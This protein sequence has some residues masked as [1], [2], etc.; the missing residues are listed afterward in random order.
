MVKLLIIL[1]FSCLLLPFTKSYAQENKI[2]EDKT[3]IRGT[4]THI[5]SEKPAYGGIKQQVKVRLDTKNK[6]QVTATYSYQSQDKSMQKLKIGESVVV[7]KTMI[8]NKTMYAVYDRFRLPTMLILVVVFFVVILVTTGR[9]GIG[10]IAGLLIS[11]AVILLFIVP[12]ILEGADP[13]FIS[14]IGCLFIMVTTIYLAHGFSQRTSIAIAGTFLSLI[15]TGILAV[16]FVQLLKLTGTGNEDAYMLQ[17]GQHAINLRGLLLGG[18]M[19]GTLGVLDDTTTTQA[20]TVYTLSETS[21]TLTVND[22]IRKGMLVGREHITSLV[23][24]LVLAYAGASLPIFIFFILN[25]MQQPFWAIVNSE[26]IV[27]EVTRTLA[28]SIGLILAVP[29]TTVLAAFF[30]KYS[31]KVT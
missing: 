24:T 22:L 29:I 19:I 7:T 31:L 15:L 8:A 21:K 10:A 25:P 11:L 6:E 9:R 14:I 27:E 4:V 26:M 13:L 3:F 16:L 28:G 12:Q 20:A 5:E 2:T 18:I 17:F 30:C 1:L 23:N